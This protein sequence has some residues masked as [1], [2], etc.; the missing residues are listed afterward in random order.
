MRLRSGGH[1][2][3]V[4][5]NRDSC[6]HV[7]MRAAETE[8]EHHCFDQAGAQVCSPPL[9]LKPCGLEEA[10]GLPG[11]VLLTPLCVPPPRGTA[12]RW[13]AGPSFVPTDAPSSPPV[14]TP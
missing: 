9:E 2:L 11:R 3:G 14:S 13:R 10:W 6:G 7:G 12:R 4:D 5:V 1:V 8:G